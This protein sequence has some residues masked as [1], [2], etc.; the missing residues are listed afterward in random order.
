M[1]IIRRCQAICQALGDPDPQEAFQQVG[2]DRL[3]CLLHSPPPDHPARKLELM[4]SGLGLRCVT[5]EMTRGR[6]PL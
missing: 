1:Q 6:E 3:P 2:Q 5:T 4:W